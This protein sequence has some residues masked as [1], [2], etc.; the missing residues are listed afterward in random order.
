MKKATLICLLLFLL[1]A[2][3]IAQS[4]EVI[5]PQKRELLLKLITA[6]GADKNIGMIFDAFM[7]AY[8]IMMPKIDESSFKV[9][10]DAPPEFRK[11]L[12]AL[13]NQTMRTI[14]DR[15]RERV[16]NDAGLK[17]EQLEIV[18]KVW[19][20]TFSEGDLRQLVEFFDSPA[21]KKLA[22]AGPAVAIETSRR[23]QE[24][25]GPYLRQIFD[26]VSREELDR[27]YEAERQLERKYDLKKRPESKP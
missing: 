14:A 12:I 13:A 17:T 10:A 6:T 20:D 18:M 19:N 1:C 5:T 8:I 23:S 21:G 25:L 2:P 7:R 27:I 26:E 9:A 15:T 16:V 24:I 4:Q 3:S 11:E 22:Q